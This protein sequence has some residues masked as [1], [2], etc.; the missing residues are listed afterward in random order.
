MVS[1]VWLEV[2][3]HK[4]TYIQP[5]RNFLYNIIT[6]VQNITR[7]ETMQL[8]LAFTRLASAAAGPS[9]TSDWI[10][11]R[12]RLTT[13]DSPQVQELFPHLWL[14]GVVVVYGGCNG[15]KWTEDKIG[16]SLTAIMFLVPISGVVVLR[17]R[18]DLGRFPS[19]HFIVSS[20]CRYLPVMRSY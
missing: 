7:S 5:K 20:I 8:A 12:V 9:R 14:T 3:V 18:N 6:S 1:T 2:P 10:N 11:W 13:H 16:D 17:Q 19:T 4:T 15:L